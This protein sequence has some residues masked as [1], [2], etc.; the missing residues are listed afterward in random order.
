[1]TL[2][3]AVEVAWRRKYVIAVV[4]VAGI[5]AVYF[6]RGMVPRTYQA[7]TRVLMVNDN[8]DPSV[9]TGDLPSVATS[10]VVLG[11]VRDQLRLRASL[12]ALQGGL[13]AR[14]VGR[15]NIMA[16]SYR[17]P[18]ADRAIAIANAVAENLSLYYHELS[19]RRYDENVDALGHAIMRQRARLT[20]I[21]AQLRGLQARDTFVAS[22]NAADN[23]TR[24]LADLENQRA[25]AA[26]T[27]AADR[28]LANVSGSR[29]GAV[30]RIARHE[31][32]Q[33]DATF[34]SLR[35]VVARDAA[36]LAATRAQYAA[37]YPGLPGE[38]A[39]VEAERAAL[40]SSAKKALKSSDA[41]SA[42]AEATANEH[43]HA[44]ALVSGDNARVAQLDRLIAVQNAQLN[45]IPRTGAAFGELRAEREAVQSEIMTLSGRHATA[46]ANRAE[47]ASLGSVVVVDRAIKADTQLSGGG[48]RLA[49]VASVLILAIAFGIAFLIEALDPR[50]RR[51]QQIERLY[52]HPVISNLGNR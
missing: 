39:K 34:R 30:S 51:A 8:R 36:Q 4:L 5:V 1:M 38:T 7:A 22:D 10:T 48:S 49:A 6:T 29:S 17:D 9:S 41:F 50:L 11:R 42:S 15:S 19:T 31:I 3:N 26:A 43:N 28:A 14:I 37:A 33:G 18:S 13:S 46:L 40:A 12:P 25:V 21:N 24:H 27:L 32:L 2:R 45:D 20:A 23:V 35:D 44:L 52:G 16:I 47:A